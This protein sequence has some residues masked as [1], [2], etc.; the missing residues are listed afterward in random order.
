M[1]F[2]L[3]TPPALLPGVNF[4]LSLD[5]GRPT[6]RLSE[7]LPIIVAAALHSEVRLR[8]PPEGQVRFRNLVHRS[9]PRPTSR[10][11]S[12]TL[13][14]PV[15]CESALEVTGAQLLDACPSVIEFGEQ[16][17]EILLPGR[18]GSWTRHIPDFVVAL[19][20]G[21][22]VIEL[23]F[24]RDI[25]PEVLARTVILQRLLAPLGITYRLLTELSLDGTRLDNAQALLRRARHASEGID[26]LLAYNEVLSHRSLP[27]GHFGWYTDGS[28]DAAT[29]AR[30]IMR[31]AVHVD[32]SAPLSSDSRV[33]VRAS[34]T[35]E[36]C[37]WPSASK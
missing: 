5:S 27:L 18:D 20:D 10:V 4:D 12:I 34:H 28:R 32:L 3:N 21:L 30:L 14:R 37:L 16:P 11:P 35:K 19:R 24:R 23:K 26:A 8:L 25:T 17:F 13:G 36:D 31:G 1:N 29:I 9:A 2:A 7:V 15:E 22:E 6:A 33:C